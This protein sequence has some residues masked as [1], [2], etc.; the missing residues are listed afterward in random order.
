MISVHPSKIRV[1]PNCKIAK[2]IF[3]LSD[4]FTEGI[5]KN[6]E[7]ASIIEKKSGKKH[8]KIRTI[9]EIKT[10]D[11]NTDPLT[12]FDRAVLSACVSELCAKNEYTTIAI[13]L[14]NL[15]G[16]IY[17]DNQP[18]IN[19]RAAIFNSIKKM[20]SMIIS[21][22][23]SDVNKEFGYNNG[24]K[25]IL[26]GSILPCEIFST[27][28]NGNLVQDVIHFFGV[29]PLYK[30]SKDRGQ[31]LTFNVNL[32]D[33]PNQNNT[34]FII[35][36]KNYSM[37]RVQEVI[38]HKMTPT[39]TFKDIFDKCRI[40]NTHPETIRRAREYIIN[41]FNHLK[42]QNII[43]DFSVI[44]SGNVFYGLQFSYEKLKKVKF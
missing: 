24:N 16:K 8:E 40:Q 42:N 1:V 6:G 30:V 32:L 9:Y 39:V 4:E 5:I 3:N 12:A 38:S 27:Y 17:A 10:N 22:D 14:R 37:T 19:Q 28:I 20:M 15:T 29:S 41:F 23:L 25:E 21:I 18:D 33:V 11:S 13:L 35:N 2:N 31:L 34:P 36:L 43:N 7:K 26:T 44:K